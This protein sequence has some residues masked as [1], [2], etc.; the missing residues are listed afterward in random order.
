MIILSPAY[1]GNLQYFSRLC[2]GNCTIDIHEHYIKQSWRNRCTIL[3]ANGP[4]SLTVQVVQGAKPCVPVCD[5]RIDYSKRWQHQH[6]GSIV[7]AYKKSP[8]FDH[9]ADSIAPFYTKKYEFLVDYDLE[10]TDTLLKLLGIEE[11]PSITD[12]YMTATASDTD[13]RAV[14]SPKPH[15]NR[16]DPQFRDAPY[17]QVFSEKFPYV[18]NLSVLDLLC[19]EGPQA[20]NVLFGCL[21]CASA[22]HL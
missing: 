21:E 18:P 15:L 10:L 6:W 17:Y 9:Y 14:F 22:S 16:P 1:L 13:L 11:R 4:I 3:S 7:S 19:C 8:Y 12:H 20:K 5:I 2:R